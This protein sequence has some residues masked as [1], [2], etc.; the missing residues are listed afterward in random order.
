MSVPLKP[1]PYECENPHP[2]P[3]QER[4]HRL[5]K[6]A[7]TLRYYY[8]DAW[9]NLPA[10]QRVDR[11]EF[12]SF[13]ASFADPERREILRALIFDLIADDVVELLNPPGG[14]GRP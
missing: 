7:P 4:W 2:S 10:P 12:V 6:I 1:V 5:Y 8:L 14:E 9:N 11:D 13:C 3:S